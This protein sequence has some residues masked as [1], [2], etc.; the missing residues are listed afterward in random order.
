MKKK[1]TK[2]K[3]KV[4]EVKRIT[5]LFILNENVSFSLEILE[6][7]GD[8]NEMNIEEK[9]DVRISQPKYSKLLKDL[10]FSRTRMVK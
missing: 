10:D 5:L 8:R 6:D 9:N 4:V 1:Q 2:L 7:E 3:K